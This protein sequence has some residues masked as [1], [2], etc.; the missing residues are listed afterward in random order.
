M[1]G[2]GI[3][4]LRKRS[5]EFVQNINLHVAE[6]IEESKELIK[7]NQEQLQESKLTTGQSITPLYSPAYAKRKG[8]KKPDGYLTGEMYRDMDIFANENNNT[9]FITSFANH[10]KYFV[11]RYGKVFGITKANQP[12][13]QK[14]AVPKLR[15]LY[16]RL[17]L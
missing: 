15:K 2:E 10:T 3:H 17:V 4:E 8:Y 12:K 11:E 13:A 5:N 16:Q 9:W 6:V 7:L 14:I 1:I